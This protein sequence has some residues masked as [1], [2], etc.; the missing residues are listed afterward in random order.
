MLQSA[1]DALIDK[2]VK[3]DPDAAAF[4]F[5]LAAQQRAKAGG[6]TSPSAAPDDDE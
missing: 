4:L 2:A 1:T 5:E 3:G 6:T